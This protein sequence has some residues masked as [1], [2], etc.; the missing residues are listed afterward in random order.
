MH[1]ASRNK[2]DHD[3]TLGAVFLSGIE[4]LQLATINTRSTHAPGKCISGAVN[5][6]VWS[7][8]AECRF[9]AVRHCLVM[10]S[11]MCS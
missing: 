4:L 6:I 8:C 11:E 2:T 5:G 1:R 10:H 9:A 7:Q 3:V